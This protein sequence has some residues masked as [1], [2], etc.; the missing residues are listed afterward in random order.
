MAMLNVEHRL[1]A[2]SDTQLSPALV[3]RRA[4]VPRT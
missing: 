4:P 1:T 2:A 3:Q